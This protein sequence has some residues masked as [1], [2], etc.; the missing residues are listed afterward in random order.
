MELL[1][2]SRRTTRGLFNA[3]TYESQ[4]FNQFSFIKPGD[5]HSIFTRSQN[6]F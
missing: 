3:V 5:K 4:K 2:R 6:T 1:N